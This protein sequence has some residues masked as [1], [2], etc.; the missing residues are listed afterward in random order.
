VTSPPA[1]E[2]QAAGQGTFAAVMAVVVTLA[3]CLSAGGI[4]RMV[5]NRRRLA[6]WDADWAIT[7]PMWSRQRW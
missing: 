6:G 3:T 5:M 7:A 1:T 2:A 4:M